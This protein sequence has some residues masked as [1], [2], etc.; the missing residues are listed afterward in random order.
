MTKEAY[1][2]EKDGLFMIIRPA[3]GTKY[4]MHMSNMPRY[5]GL[6]EEYQVYMN[7]QMAVK[8]GWTAYTVTLEQ[9]PDDHFDLDNF[10][11]ETRIFGFKT[12]DEE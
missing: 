11:M 7:A 9:I 4:Y 8:N 1:Y 12:E 5:S 3:T 10:E 2:F 6:I